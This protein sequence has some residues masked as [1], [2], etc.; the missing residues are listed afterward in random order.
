MTVTLA[1]RCLT[2]AGSNADACGTRLYLAPGLR[3]SA[4]GDEAAGGLENPG[5]KRRRRGS[6]ILVMILLIG[7]IVLEKRLCC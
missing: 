5:G 6:K 2:F 7:T 3:P 1:G 4:G